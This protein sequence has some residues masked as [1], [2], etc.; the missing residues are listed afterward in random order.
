MR[1]SKSLPP[2]QTFAGCSG[3]GMIGKA[4]LW[5]NPGKG[6]VLTPRGFGNKSY[7]HVML[8]VRETEGNK[9]IKSMKWPSSKTMRN[10]VFFYVDP[11]GKRITFR[12]VDEFIPKGIPKT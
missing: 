1:V 3:V 5:L 7:Y 2:K 9:V 8:G 4:K 10:Y 6:T 11:I 12:G